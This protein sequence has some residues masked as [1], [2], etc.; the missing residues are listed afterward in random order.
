MGTADGRHASGRRLRA[1]GWIALLVGAL[2]CAS[3][4][5]PVPDPVSV[6]V[7]TI[8]RP[9]LEAALEAVPVGM[10]RRAERLE[11]LFIEAGCGEHTRSEMPGGTPEANVVCELPGRSPWTI[12]VGA[13]LDR[14]SDGIGAVDN[15]SGIALLPSLYQAVAAAPREHTYLFAGFAHVALKQ[16]GSRQFLRRLG[17]EGRARIRAMI[18]L[19]GL[20]LGTTAIWSTQADRNLRQDLF[21]VTKALDLPLRETRFFSNVSVDAQSFRYYDIPTLT[22]HSFD[23]KSARVLAQPGLDRSPDRID[24]QDYFDTAR[25]LGV[26]LA[27]LDDTYRIRAADSTPAEQTGDSDSP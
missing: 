13:N 8:D 17:E 12:L 11:A 7:G 10:H 22:V 21:A 3:D 1:T 25:T 6:R 2:A 15:W 23:R 4:F 20:G 27:Y 16:R 14:A 26:Y 19:K 18:S 9:T 5:T 24:R